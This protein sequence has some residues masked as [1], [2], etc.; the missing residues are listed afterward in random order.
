MELTA[1]NREI[2]G[3]KVKILR[4]NG[5]TPVH[6]FGHQVEPLPLQCDTVELQRI[7]TQTGK[8][9]L[10]NLKLE[11]TSQQRNVMVREVQREPRS[12]KLLHVDF[13]QV[14][15]DEKLRVE[16]P[17][18]TV[19]EA[20][21]LKSKENFLAHEL[22]TLNIECLPDEIPGK[23]EVD[24]SSLTEDE[25]AI[26][27]RDIVLPGNIT[28]LDHPDQMVVKITSGYVEKEEA[29]AEAR[30]EAPEEAAATEEGEVSSES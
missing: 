17:I 13:Y 19:G 1:N 2:L 5:I 3:K 28:V 18:V 16:V 26:H 25:Q 23:I 14:R 4:R 11:S 9:G 27:V 22:N 20:P 21:A 12:G 7:L 30:A 6:L 29:A 24:I 15:M 8:T 10:I